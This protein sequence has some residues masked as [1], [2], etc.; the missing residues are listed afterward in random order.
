MKKEECPAWGKVFQVD[1]GATANTRHGRFLDKIE[2]TKRVLRMSN[3]TGTKALGS[4][5][6]MVKNPKN[7]QG[8]RLCAVDFLV[9]SAGY[10]PL[11]GYRT[12]KTMKLLNINDR[13]IDKVTAVTPVYQ[14][15][16]LRA[17]PRAAHLQVDKPTP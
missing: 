10:T 7:Y 6:D 13:N 16:K 4:C 11:L 12:G 8:L 9:V 2:P 3:V 14:N 1:S 5:H 15:G 17:L